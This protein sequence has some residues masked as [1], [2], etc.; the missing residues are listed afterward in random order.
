MIALSQFDDCFLR[1]LVTTEGQFGATEAFL[2]WYHTRW[3]LTVLPLRYQHWFAWNVAPDRLDNQRHTSHEGR[4]TLHRRA[5]HDR[6]ELLQT[7]HGQGAQHASERWS[8]AADQVGV[9]AR[10]LMACLSLS[11]DDYCPAAWP[12]APLA[13]PEQAALVD[14]R[15]SW[16]GGRVVPVGPPLPEAAS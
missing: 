5:N 10:N 14:D 15:D 9:G 2:T 3:Q 7:I 11:E 6:H 16:D 1:S 8:G 12:V 4:I 13:L